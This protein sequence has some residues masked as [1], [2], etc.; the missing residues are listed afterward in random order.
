[1]VN[2][3]ISP[4]KAILLIHERIDAITTIRQNEFGFPEYYEVI[5][6][7]SKTWPVIDAIYGSDDTHQEE[8]RSIGLFNCSCDSTI[9]AQILVEVYHARLLDYINEIQDSMKTPR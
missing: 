8:I 4:E 2:L 6:W 9:A 7:C 1:M 3:K 5:G